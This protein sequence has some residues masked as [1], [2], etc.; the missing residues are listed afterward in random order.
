[1]T[2]LSGRYYGVRIPAAAGWFMKTKRTSIRCINDLYAS[3]ENQLTALTDLL[4]IFGRKVIGFIRKVSA[5]IVEDSCKFIILK[6]L[7]P[8]HVPVV[9]PGFLFSR[10]TVQKQGDQAHSITAYRFT[11]DQGWNRPLHT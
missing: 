3:S 11:P 10:H 6:I 2:P 7:K 1:M 5:D 4:H 8:G 9:L